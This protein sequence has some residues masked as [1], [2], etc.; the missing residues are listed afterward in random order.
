MDFNF[1][2]QDNLRWFVTDFKDQGNDL[3]KQKNYH[4]ANEMYTVALNLCRHLQDYHYVPIENELLSILFSNRA[5][6]LLKM[7]S[8]DYSNN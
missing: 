2:F 4:G 6:C 5:F 1:V 8:Y 3:F 7:V